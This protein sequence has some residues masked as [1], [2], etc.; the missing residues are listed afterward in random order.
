[1]QI[2]RKKEKKKVAK[3]NDRHVILAST[4]PTGSVNSLSRSVV[5]KINFL[6]IK[7]FHYNNMYI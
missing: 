1:M 6:W 2:S 4:E 3:L 5:L 7:F